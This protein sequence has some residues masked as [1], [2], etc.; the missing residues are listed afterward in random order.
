MIGNPQEPANPRITSEIANPE[1]WTQ[2]PNSASDG[3]PLWT[4]RIAANANGP[5]A[6]TRTRMPRGQLGHQ[7]VQLGLVR[8][9]DARR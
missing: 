3:V 7:L 6:Q 8:V 2:A 5:I 9:A 1:E 4:L